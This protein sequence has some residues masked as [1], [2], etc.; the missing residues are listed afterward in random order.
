MNDAFTL[1][2]E[3]E[4]KNWGNIYR[5]TYRFHTALC[6]PRMVQMAVSDRASHDAIVKGLRNMADKIEEA[7]NDS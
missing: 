7:F 6:K 3:P 4:T 1:S 2:I 5:L